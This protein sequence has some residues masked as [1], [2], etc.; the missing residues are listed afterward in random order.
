LLS[1]ADIADLDGGKV[2]EVEF[3]NP[4]DLT[5]FYV[6]VKPDSG[7]WKGAPYKFLLEIPADYVSPSC[8]HFFFHFVM[9]EPSLTTLL[10]HEI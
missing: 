3:P 6:I 5:I 10:L 8:H 2:A 9:H 1:F 4:N 7:Y